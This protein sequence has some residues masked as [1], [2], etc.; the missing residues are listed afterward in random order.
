MLQN[1]AKNKP[2][3]HV[4]LNISAARPSFKSLY[5]LFDQVAK[6]AKVQM[7]KCKH[8]ADIFGHFV[9][10]FERWSSSRDIEGNMQGGMFLLHFAAYP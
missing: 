9:E 10:I 6:D 7:F 8:T 3:L 2:R 4:S 5:D 1:E